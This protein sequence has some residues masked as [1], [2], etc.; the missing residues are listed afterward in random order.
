[1]GRIGQLQN[2]LVAKEVAELVPFADQMRLS[3]LDHHFRRFEAGVEIG[4]H[5]ESIGAGIIEGKIVAFADFIDGAGPGEGIRFA[6]I[7]YDRVLFRRTVGV[8]DI[9]DPMVGIVEHRADQVIEAAVDA[10]ECRSCRLFDHIHL[11]DE[12]AGFA[13]E[14]FAG[15][16][17]YLK[18][19]SSRIGV[20]GEC[21]FDGRGQQG[22]I[23]LYIAVLVGNLEA[24]AQ[25]D[26]FQFF[27]MRDDIEKDFD[28]FDKN[29]NVLDFAARM[30]VEIRN[31]QIVL[32]NDLQHLID[33]ID[34]NAKLAFIVAS[35]NLQVAAGHDIGAEADTNWVAVTEL[36]T[37]FFEIGETVDIDGN[38]ERLGFLDFVEA[39]AVRG[40]QYPGGGKAGMESQFHLIDA[41][42]VD[43]CSDLADIFEDVD[44]R[45]CLTGVEEK[46]IAA[47]ES[48]CQF[49][50]LFFYLFGV[51]NVKGSS[52]FFPQASQV[53]G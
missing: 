39:N 22:N 12:I 11:G 14:E 43:I 8:A 13:H 48:R 38:P 2:D 42:A 46:C 20:I 15:F 9:F 16:E 37:E 50:V 4:G 33:L 45:E 44:I 52:E 51:I 21:L 1:M 10:D 23:R 27:E 53:F 49:M 41:A 26:E 3:V 24:A 6:D 30:D 17:P 47:L 35:R 19:S 40:I 18:G 32:L 28:A 34:G 31:V 5:F 25:I 29:F 7:T 36:L